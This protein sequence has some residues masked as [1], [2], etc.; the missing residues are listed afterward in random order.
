LDRETTIALFAAA[1]MLMLLARWGDT[2]RR[3]T[4]HGGLALMPWHALMFVALVGMLFLGVHLLS[5]FGV[6]N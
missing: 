6:R 5:F 2:R 1:V 3:R 4:P